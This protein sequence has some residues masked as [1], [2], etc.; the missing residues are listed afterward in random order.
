ME[1][2]TKEADSPHGHPKS[3]VNRTMKHKKKLCLF[4]SRHK[5]IEANPGYGSV[6]LLTYNFCDQIID[7]FKNVEYEFQF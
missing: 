1:N 4:L 6:H 2:F 7:F 3:C 5:E